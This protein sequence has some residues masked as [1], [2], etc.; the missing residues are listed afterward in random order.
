[1]GQLLRFVIFTMIIVGDRVFNRSN[2]I[3]VQ[4]LKLT[5]LLCA[6]TGMAASLD[7]G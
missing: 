6:F 7:L 1:V 4:L 3:L 2:G 5:L